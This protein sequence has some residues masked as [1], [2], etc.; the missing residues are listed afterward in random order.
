VLEVRSLVFGGVVN[1]R[2]LISNSV[3]D[4]FIKNLHYFVGIFQNTNV[5]YI[6]LTLK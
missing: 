4:E 1:L 2:C 5:S 3:I 6:N